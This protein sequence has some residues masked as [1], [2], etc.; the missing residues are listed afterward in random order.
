VSTT[1][2]L[3]KQ[4]LLMQMVGTRLRAHMDIDVEVGDGVQTS[5]LILCMISAYVV[6]HL[7]LCPLHCVDVQMQMSLASS[8]LTAEVRPCANRHSTHQAQY[9][10]SG[11]G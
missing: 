9:A 3:C 6:V 11:G 7:I 10:C 1:F 8:Y 2:T 4:R 5:S